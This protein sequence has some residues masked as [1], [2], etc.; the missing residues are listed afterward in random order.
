MYNE[1]YHQ[2][3]IFFLQSRSEYF[4]KSGD[5]ISYFFEEKA[6]DEKGNLKVKDKFASSLR[7][8]LNQIIWNI[9]DRFWKETP[10]FSCLGKQSVLFHY[11]GKW[12]YYSNQKKR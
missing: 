12:W 5:N 6:L 9:F 3:L 11:F 10:K 7:I 1:L 8:S 4:L 2:Y